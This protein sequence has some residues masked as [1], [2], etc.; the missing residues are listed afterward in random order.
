MFET[1]HSSGAENKLH[2]A[3]TNLVLS[4]KHNSKNQP[5][6]QTQYNTNKTKFRDWTNNAI[7]DEEPGRVF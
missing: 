7:L 2:K 3:E 1:T 4:I 6:K 5:N